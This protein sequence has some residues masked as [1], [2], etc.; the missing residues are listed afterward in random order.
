MS[1]IFADVLAR[2]ED[3]ETADAKFR[4]KYGPAAR[5]ER[6]T[7]G[8]LPTDIA[9]GC[10]WLIPRFER[11]PEGDAAWERHCADTRKRVQNQNQREIALVQAACGPDRPA[12]TVELR[13][14]SGKLKR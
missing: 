7:L 5:L 4:A 2:L 14:A 1:D 13:T 12:P 10:S 3:E 8:V 11:S 9:R 6:T